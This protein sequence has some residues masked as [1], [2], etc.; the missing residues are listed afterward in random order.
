MQEWLETVCYSNDQQLRIL[1]DLLSEKYK[2]PKTYH[3][4]NDDIFD[5]STFLM[6]I[7]LVVTP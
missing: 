7:Q 3:A 2:V 4:Y 5:L 1:C 6:A